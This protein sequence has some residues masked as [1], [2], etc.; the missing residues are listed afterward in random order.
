M[1]R[2]RNIVS[3]TY[4]HSIRSGRWNVLGAYRMAVEVY[5]Q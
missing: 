2:L 5:N 4:R 3:F 1:M